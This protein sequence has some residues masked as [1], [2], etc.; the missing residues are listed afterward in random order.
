MD[1]APIQR[2]IEA[3]VDSWNRRDA[4]AF[5]GC[6]AEDADYVTG[7][8]DRWSG[9]ETIGRRMKES[10]SEGMTGGTA[11]IA[12]R[13]VR[14]LG[15]DRAAAHLHWHLM[16]DDSTAQHTF[17]RSGITVLVVGLH[18]GRWLIE[19]AQNTDAG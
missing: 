9:R 1:D 11:V 16:E 19:V 17:P 14:G 7:E 10:W 4:A 5:A 8:A 6:F 18:D 2:L 12:R 15:P 13:T 3:L